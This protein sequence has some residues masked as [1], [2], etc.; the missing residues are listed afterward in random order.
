[1]NNDSVDEK[2]Y[3]C[4]ACG[5]V[6]TE[7]PELVEVQRQIWDPPDAAQPAIYDQFC[8]ACKGHD[9]FTEVEITDVVPDY[10]D[11]CRHSCNGECGDCVTDAVEAY[12]AE[13]EIWN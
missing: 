7:E 11:R 10:W 4:D 5:N 6:L 9:T 13:L 3:K 12:N 2:L 8:E 1:M